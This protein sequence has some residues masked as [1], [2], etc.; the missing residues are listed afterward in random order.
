MN[1][2][3]PDQHPFILL[4][5]DDEDDLEILSSALKL[6][7]ATVKSF[8]SSEGALLYLAIQPLNRE[9]PAL[10]IL[11]YNLPGRNGHE[12]LLSIINN[13]DI[14]HIPVLIY[15]TGMSEILRDQLMKDGAV[16]CLEKA[17][18]AEEFNLN[19]DTLANLARS[20][21]SHKKSA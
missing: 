21:I 19:V 10:I 18:N 12:V 9:V 13:L 16:G 11:D 4:V 14:R 20:F 5:D 2:P 3:V 6:K 7:G 1:S 15:S 8:K 17:W